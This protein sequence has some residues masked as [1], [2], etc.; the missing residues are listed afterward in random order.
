[1]KILSNLMVLSVW[2]HD[3]VTCKLIV[4]LYVT[5]M[6]EFLCGSKGHKKDHPVTGG[7][8]SYAGFVYGAFVPWTLKALK[9]LL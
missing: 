9:R 5:S 6:T 1:M 4:E 8:L 7:L 3:E 2:V